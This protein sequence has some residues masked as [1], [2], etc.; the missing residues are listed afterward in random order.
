MTCGTCF[1]GEPVKDRIKCC[2]CPPIS[3]GKG[4]KSVDCQPIM[5]TADW[6]GEYKTHKK[7]DEAKHADMILE[8][9]MGRTVFWSNVGNREKWP[10][11]HK[12]RWLWLA[13]LRIRLS[14]LG[15]R[16]NKQ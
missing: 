15:R 9:Y 5:A 10:V 14:N 13:K 7:M 12:S 3:D 16:N 2:R 4:I 6:C 11:Y 8:H 1:F